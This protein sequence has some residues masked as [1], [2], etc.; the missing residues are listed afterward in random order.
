[1]I[2]SIRNEEDSMDV[3]DERIDRFGE[4]PKAVMGLIT[5]SQLRSRA[6]EAGIKEIRQVEGKYFLQQQ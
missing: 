3:I 4:P 5:V 1:M 6:A 2:A